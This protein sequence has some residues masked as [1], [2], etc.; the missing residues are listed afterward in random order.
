MATVHSEGGT[1]M[2][3][4]SCRKHFDSN[5]KFDDLQYRLFPNLSD[6]ATFIE[7]T[8]G[9]LAAAVAD[10]HVLVLV[11]G[12]RNPLKNVAAAY[13]KLENELTTRGLIGLGNYDLAVGFIW[14]GFQTALGFFPAV[15]WANRSAAYFRTF[16]KLL[17]SSAHT[18][19]V[20]THSLG[21]RVALQAL[22][23]DQEVFVDNLMMTAAA[24]DNEILEPKE[25]FNQ[26]LASCRRCL[27]Y[28][29]SKDP[30]LKVLYRIGSLDK[31]L[32]AK[33]PEHPKVI[34][35]ECPE[36][37]IV[38]CS[39]VVGSHGGYRAAPEVYDHWERVLAD[40]PVPRF[41]VLK[42]QK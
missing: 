26:S 19:D 30:V 12:F 14:P 8:E 15:P 40:D 20:E 11:H 29:S 6:T 13:K 1:P 4:A 32:G 36:V 38:D 27:V 22:A 33:G 7:L 16:M 5:Q 24:V 18:V 23:F 39:A 35:K 28:H 41:D 3:L 34:E 2:I 21:A 31:A 10:K 37:F 17:N 9:E 42:K 25:E